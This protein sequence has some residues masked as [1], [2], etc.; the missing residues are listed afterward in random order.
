MALVRQQVELV[1][2]L[3]DGQQELAYRLLGNAHADVLTAF[4]ATLKT[5]YL[6]K[7]GAFAA[8]ADAV[9]PVGNAFQ[10]IERGQKRY[11]EFGFDPFER[12]APDALATLTLN[13]QK[14]HVIGHNLGIVD[15]AFAEHAA[16]ARLG[17]SIP[18]VGEDILQFAQLG[19][20]VINHVDAWLANGHSPPTEVRLEKPLMPPPSPTSA[21]LQIGQLGS[22]AVQ[23]GCWIAEQS[24]NG[25]GDF[26]SEEALSQAFPDATLDDL[27]F[28][29]AE[30]AKDGYLSATHVISKR[31]PRMRATADTYITF[32]PHTLKHDPAID[33]AALV[34][35]ALAE[36][37]TVDVAKLHAA[38]GWPRRRFNPAFAYM[39]AQIDDRRVLKGGTNA[40]P[41]RGFLLLDEDRVD[42]KR[43]AARVRPR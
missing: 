26:V 38:S 24:Q 39:I 40:Y 11:A 43:F 35:L 28:A 5:V 20:M 25:F 14:R 21:P 36:N 7:A 23:I 32:D 6:Y 8:N 13:I 1:A 27:G 12:L 2:K 17:E 42:L 18:L 16:D 33:A 41:A 9:K 4:E 30:L 22:L 31:L 10:N 34:D 3:E 29:V 15:A 19:Q 37:N